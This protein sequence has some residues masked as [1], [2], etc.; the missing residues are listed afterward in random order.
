M[1]VDTKIEDELN[2]FRK[3]IQG[4]A[5]KELEPEYLGWEKDGN[6]PR[7]LWN[8]LG[9]EGLLNIDIPEK[10]GGTGA[11]FIYSSTVVEELSYL[12]YPA[13]AGNISVHSN[14]VAHYI[15]ASGTEEQKN[16]YLP[17]MATGE[18]IG[19]IAMTEPNA[20]SDLQGIKTSAVFDESKNMYKLNGSKTF[21]SNGQ[22]CDFVIVA[23]R[24]D[25]S[26]AGSRGTTLFIVDLPTVGFVK[27]KNLEKIGLHAS[28]TSEH[29]MEDVFVPKEKVLGN[30]HRGFEILMKEL[31]KERFIL[32]IGAQGAM[33]GIMELTIKY[34]KEREA[35]GKPISQFQ[36][37]RFRMAE[38]KT[39]VRIHRAFVNECL[40]L[41]EQDKLDTETASMAKL[42]CTEAQGRI[43]DGCL[44]M[45]GGYGYMQEYPVARAF[46]DA[47]VQRIYGGTSEIM[48]EIIGKSIFGK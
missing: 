3:S 9:D 33:E 2:L 10:Y 32:A 40:E 25:L 12:Q 28:D 4:F 44:Q 14:I 16:H 45:F 27:G 18:L 20:G 6:I 5:K 37:T 38:M 22:H 35:F 39:E 31:P 8:R 48:K 7:K 15:L 30:L 19:A 21:I 26:V 1:R 34:A 43:A 46:V 36:N 42:S 13:I 17:K 23:A 29:F 47:R 11:P 41:I 24:T